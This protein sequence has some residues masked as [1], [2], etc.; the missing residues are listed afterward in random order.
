MPMPLLVAPPVIG[1]IIGTMPGVYSFVGSNMTISSTLG[2]QSLRLNAFFVPKITIFDRIGCE[3]TTGGE[4][5]SIIRIGIYGDNGFQ[6]PGSLISESGTVTAD[7]IAIK[8]ITISQLLQPGLYWMGGC[9]QGA[10]TTQ[11]AVRITDE[12]VNVDGPSTTTATI[13]TDIRC[14]V[15]TAVAGALPATFSTSVLTGGRSLRMFIRAS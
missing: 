8:E 11:P 9:I 4:A 15:Q 13:T 10:P 1:Q 6:Y 2:N 5:G 14:Y 3:V 12:M 7:T